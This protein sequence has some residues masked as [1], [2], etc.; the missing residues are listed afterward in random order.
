[1]EIE[2]GRLANLELVEVSGFSDAAT[3]PGAER[4]P[5]SILFRGP[6]DLDVAQRM[7]KLNHTELG[8]HEIFLVPIGPDKKGT[9]FEAVFS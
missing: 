5:F 4:K 3:R 9:R 2:P 8:A 1:M 6:L 7:F